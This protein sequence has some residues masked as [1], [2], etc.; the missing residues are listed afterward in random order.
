M[1]ELTTFPQGGD[2]SW[3][4]MPKPKAR[5]MGL[6]RTTILELIEEGAVKSVVIRKRHALRGIRL[7]FLP[8]LLEHLDRLHEE[9]HN[10]KFIT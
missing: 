3:V 2:A 10:P 4:R 9:Q 7:I 8:S 1:L 6:S 5:L